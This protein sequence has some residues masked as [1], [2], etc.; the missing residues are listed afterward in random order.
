MKLK[1]YSFLMLVLMFLNITFVLAQ[2]KTISGTISDQSGMPLP[3]VNIIVKGTTTGAQSDF[4]GNYTINAS[5]G[6]VLSFTYVGL[7][8]VDITVGASNSLNVTMEE[9]ATALD[10]VVITALGISKDKKK[11]GY[12]I[13]NVGSEIL[14]KSSETNILNAINGRVSGVSI[15]SAGGDVGASSNIV[16]RGVSSV[17]GNNQALFVVD[18][19][20]IDNTTTFSGG[21]AG[22]VAGANRGSDIDFNNVASISVLKGGAATVLYGERGANGVI[23]I[24]TKTGEQNNR[25]NVDFSTSYTTST[26]NRYPKFQDKYAR[27]RNGA[28]SNVTHWSWGP[29]YETN[30]K[31]PNGTMAD[32]NG[33]GIQTN[34]GG[35]PIPQYFDNW[36][37]F[38][39]TGTNLTH[40]L[41]L[42][43]GNEKGRFFASATKSD[44]EGIVP[45]S[46][47]KR[48]SVLLNGSY[49]LS[50][51]LSVGGSANFIQTKR[52]VAASSFNG[53]GSGLGYFHHMWDINTWNWKDANGNKTWFSGSVPDPLWVVNEENENSLVNRV[54]GNVNVN[55][56]F[57]DWFNVSYKLGLDNYTDTRKV[58]RPISSVNTSG[59]NPNGPGGA[60]D[61]IVNNITSTIV[62]SDFL[63]TGDGDLTDKIGFG[64]MVGNNV[65][66]ANYESLTTEGV[67]QILPGFTNITNY[68][69][70]TASSYIEHVRILGLFGELT[71]DYD[72]TVFLGLTARNDWSSTLPKKNNSYF[73]PSANLGFI[74][75]NVIDNANWLNFG[76]LRGSLAQTG[77]GADAYQIQDVYVRDGDNISGQPRFTISNTSRNPNLLPEI[78]TE[79]EVGLEMKMFQSKV[80][81]DFTYYN[82]DTDNQITSVPVP[83]TTGYGFTVINSGLINN[84]GIEVLLSINDLIDLGELKWGFDFNFSKNENVVKE[85]TEGFGDEIRIS[86]GWWSSTNKV[87]KVGYSTGTLTGVGYERDPQG[88]IYIG[89]DGNPL[90]AANNVIIGDLNPDWIGNISGNLKYKGFG[91][92][93][94]LEFKK[95]GDIVNDSEGWWVYAGLAKSTENRYY[96]G[97]PTSTASAIIPGIIKSTGLPNNIAIPLDNNYY[98]NLIS[99]NDEVL[100]EDASWIRLRNVA[101]TY[102]VP[103]KFLEKTGFHSLQVGLLGKNLWLDTKYDGK[104]PEVNSRGAGNGS[105]F[106]INGAPATKSLTLNVKIG[107]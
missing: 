8:A 4:D 22:N 49:N 101:L 90:L 54:L 60:G 76:K 50:D 66:D 20:P 96:P 89:D 85:L 99:F 33:D 27:G 57:S 15:T 28:Y 68:T 63:I 64:Y 107:F 30:P 40:N 61:G 93:Y 18:G 19:V 5:A 51:K 82:K 10:E 12:A 17:T 86:G 55:Y 74:F 102:D 77:K 80:G 14:E 92:N 62:N 24:T 13:E 23:L 2:N 81:L 87:A 29:N 100:V 95:G 79:W 35:T 91:L 44:E 84:K 53:W 43:G 25:L 3:G 48:F 38:F 71:F 75:S 67:A 72:N 42:S 94:L 37:N 52:R 104:D 9:D 41:S 39:D 73:Y 36:K 26:P 46:E 83:A 56:A 31:F 45:N 1:N 106:D 105:G 58:F 69:T 70:V 6:D 78:S 47:N 59:T 16:I 21:N 88:N 7:K 11:V 98:Q 32:I 103:S 97:D 34:V 65:Y